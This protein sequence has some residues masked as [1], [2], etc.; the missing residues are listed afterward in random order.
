MFLFIFTDTRNSKYTNTHT[1]VYI[2]IRTSE[3]IVI[4]YIYAKNTFFRR[5]FI[6]HVVQRL[7]FAK[8]FAILAY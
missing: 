2:Q 5:D 8:S 3:D 1:H 6:L 7:S 4:Y